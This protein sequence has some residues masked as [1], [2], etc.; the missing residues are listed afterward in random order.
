MNKKRILDYWVMKD[1]SPRSTQ[2]DGLEWMERQPSHIK[3]FLIEAPVG[4]GKSP[5]ALTASSWFSGGF[6][7]SVILTP[8]KILQRQYENS[9]D[10]NLIGSIYGKSNYTCQKKRTNCDIGDSIKPKCQMCP[11]RENFN[12]AKNKPNVVLN[13]KIA[14]LFSMIG[15]EFIRRKKVMILD[16]CHTLEHHLTEFLAVQ[17]SERACKKYGVAWKQVK[18]LPEALYFV[19]EKYLPAVEERIVELEKLVNEI[20]G[21]SEAGFCISED[22]AAL[23]KEFESIKEQHLRLQE[24]TKMPLDKLQEHYVF[25]PEKTFFRFKELYGANVFKSLVEPLADK[26]IFMSAT[27]LD[28]DEF[29]RDLGID[30]TKAAFISMKSEFDVSRRPVIFMPVM[31]MTYGWD[32]PD[33]KKDRDE[34]VK[35]IIEICTEDHAEHSGVIHTANFQVSQWLVNELQGKI[36]QKIYHHNPDGEK[37]RDEVI[38][39]FIKLDGQKKLLISPSVTEGLDLKGDLARFNI[40]AKTPFPFL[41]DAWVKARMNRSQ[42]WYNRQAMISVI[43]ACGR[44]VR[45]KDDWGYTYI[46][47]SSFISLYNRMKHRIPKWWKDGFITA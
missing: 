12:Q 9:F 38:D 30:P 46:L 17:I 13:Y 44:P 22:D 35:A 29:C 2:I 43:Q 8:Q 32:G 21:R 23:I 45:S 25:I 7:S 6:G 20:E 5:L 40:I 15:V 39:E 31:K 42:D 3:Y 18:T 33:K 14:L 28:K 11:Y 34:M 47:D 1:S 4:A 24:I 16:E 27:I 19:N 36:P 37:T 10:P 41:G 26:F